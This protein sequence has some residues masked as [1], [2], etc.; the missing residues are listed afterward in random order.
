MAFSPCRTYILYT[1]PDHFSLHG[2]KVDD[3]LCT[4]D[5]LTKRNSVHIAISQ[6]SFQIYPYQMVPTSFF[7]A[8][9]RPQAF[10]HFKTQ[11]VIPCG[12]LSPW[13]MHKRQTP[14]FGLQKNAPQNLVNIF[15][16][17]KCFQ[18]D[19]GK[20]GCSTGSPALQHIVKSQFF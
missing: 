2:T 15:L 10:T 3:S 20:R 11:L 6:K 16:F 17:N 14:E 9:P 8:L 4:N 19:L 5:S 1:L 12:H 18:T 7:I 13:L